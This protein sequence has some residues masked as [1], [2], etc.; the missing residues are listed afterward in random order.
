LPRYAARRVLPATVEDVWAIVAEPERFAEWW[1]GLA[2]VEPTVR[3]ALT[4]G[5]LWR[6]EGSSRPSLRPRPQLTGTLLI[7]EVA[8]PRRLAFQLS[9]DRIDVELDLEATA[10]DEAAAS[11]VVEAPRF[12]GVGRTFPSDVLAKLAAL[13]RPAAS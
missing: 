3:R 8:P 11:L 12:R 4:P 7:L 6:V 13:V 9:G 5:A 2:H 10:D 1:P